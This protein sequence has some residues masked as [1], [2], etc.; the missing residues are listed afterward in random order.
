[1][2]PG[3]LL[4]RG[5][6]ELFLADGAESAHEDDDG[7]AIEHAAAHVEPLNVAPARPIRPVR[8]QLSSSLAL[9]FKVCLQKGY[10]ERMPRSTHYF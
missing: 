2:V 5:R 1:M 4:R 10:M 3:G 9:A 7:V 8:L 6:H